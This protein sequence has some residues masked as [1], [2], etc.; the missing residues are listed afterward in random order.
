[1][2]P[3][4]TRVL[5]VAALVGAVAVG[6]APSA[7]SAPSD[8]ETATVTPSSDLTN[9]AVVTVAF[10]NF[11][12]DATLSIAQCKAAVTLG[13]DCDTSTLEN[14][15]SDASGNGTFQYTVE[16]LEPSGTRSF[17]CN[18][19]TPCSIAVFAN[20]NEFTSNRAV[21]PITFGGGAATTTTVAGA[22]TTTTVAS[23][24]TTTV[25]GET[26][27]TDLSEATT[28]TRPPKQATSLVAGPTLARIL[29]NLRILFPD[30]NAKLTVLSSGAPLAERWI[31]FSAGGGS[32]C[33]A[34]TDS[35]GVA[36]CEAKAPFRA[37]FGF[38][39]TAKFTGDREYARSVDFAPLLD[40][41]FPDA[42]V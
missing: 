8:A 26:T 23:T 14:A 21:V 42:D 5:T 32:I 17:S 18:A 41:Q 35:A 24:T 4:L 16:T 40:I 29:P 2:G 30:L 13:E 38:G 31:K 19:A 3:R 11:E 33:Y 1:M 10:N 34:Q 37:L 9:G 39:Y 20:I 27:T 25:A 22:T 36:K 12:P 15:E 7:V 6:A 28:T